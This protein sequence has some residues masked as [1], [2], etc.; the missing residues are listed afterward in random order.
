MVPDITGGAL[1]PRLPEPASN[2]SRPSSPPSSSSS[3]FAPPPPDDELPSELKAHDDITQGNEGEEGASD[4]PDEDDDDDDDE[5]LVAVCRDDIHQKRLSMESG[6]SASEKHLEDDVVAVEM[7]EQQQ[8]QPQQL[9][10][11]ELPSE[12]LSLPS[13]QTDGKLANRDSGIDSISSPSHSEELCFAGVDDGGV[14]YSCSP[15]LL[16]RLS[17]SSSYAGDGGEGEARGGAR[18]RR[19]F[20]EEGDSD[21]EEEEAELTLVLPPPK[22]DRQDSTEVR[23]EERET[24]AQPEHNRTQPDHNQNTS[25]TQPEHN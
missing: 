9:D 1:C 8:Q 3:S 2:S 24:R 21:L 22:T 13:S 17:S 4:L 10:Q 16:P 5:E 25:R 23:Q 20:S 19:G 14:V 11:S 6:Y 12:R 15:A 7:R 18:R